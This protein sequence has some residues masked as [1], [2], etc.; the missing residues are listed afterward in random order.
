MMTLALPTGR[1]GDQVVS[2][3]KKAKLLD[4]DLVINRQLLIQTNGLRLLWVKPS[5]VIT[6]VTSAQA[7]I[8]IVGSDVLLEQQPLVFDVLDLNIGLCSL[9]LAGL[10]DRARQPSTQPIKIATKYTYLTQQYFDSINQPIEIVSLKG[11]VE[12]APL[13]D[14]ADGIVDITETGRTLK[15]NG[16][17]ILQT[18]LPISARLIV[19]QP[20]YY[21]KTDAIERIRK[22]LQEVIE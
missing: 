12:L 8:G 17:T 9:I 11:S 10:D 21:L 1:L 14:V 3:L 22:Q 2:L 19:S 6:Y 15:E 5:D 16:L 20:S 18:I 4:E 13:I 7:D